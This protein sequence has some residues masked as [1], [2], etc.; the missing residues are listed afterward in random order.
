MNLPV[1]R[2]TAAPALKS[3][4]V[5]YSGCQPL[6]GSHYAEQ[7]ILITKYAEVEKA[8]NKYVSIMAFPH[9][10]IFINSVNQNSVWLPVLY[11]NRYEQNKY[12]K[13][14]KK[15]TKKGKKI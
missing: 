14:G 2:A 11:A 10:L 9:C 5:K 13:K 1:C 12:Q 8:L 7:Q 3:A 15:V 6:T 4:F